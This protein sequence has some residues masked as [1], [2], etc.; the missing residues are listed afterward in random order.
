MVDTT[1]LLVLG[2]GGYFYMKE[3]EKKKKEQ[4]AAGENAV[5]PEVDPETGE[6]I[7]PESSHEEIPYEA[8]PEGSEWCEYCDCPYNG[9][10]DNDTDACTCKGNQEYGMDKNSDACRCEYNPDDPN[11]LAPE[12]IECEC[13]NNPTK[14]KCIDRVGLADE[15]IEGLKITG[16]NAACLIGAKTEQ[17][18]CNSDSVA[19]CKA[20]QAGMVALGVIGAT[21]APIDLMSNGLK[22]ALGKERTYE[23]GA[24][25]LAKT[26]NGKLTTKDLEGL[27]VGGDALK[28][29]IKSEGAST[30]VKTG[31]MIAFAF[32]PPGGFLQQMAV[33]AVSALIDALDPY[34][35]DNIIVKESLDQVYMDVGLELEAAISNAFDSCL[36]RAGCGP[37]NSDEECDRAMQDDCYNYTPI[38]DM[39]DY[40]NATPTYVFHPKPPFPFCDPDTDE[41]CKQ[42]DVYNKALDEYAD[43]HIQEY[44]DA[45][46]DPVYTEE[47]T[48]PETASFFA[49]EAVEGPLKKDNMKFILPALAFLLV[50]K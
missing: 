41:L 30:G 33:A 2:A 4:A 25:V 12:T 24:D 10:Y 36:E 37:D 43:E 7:Y 29:N 19:A 27:G 8:D 5:E 17:C 35:Y 44:L 32:A 26:R 18:P 49:S 48:D 40:V 16:D 21:M 46:M 47:Y 1:T 11:A 42:D 23:G 3:Q 50:A 28:G 14:Q 39:G 13:L 22:K 6:L 34:D 15:T 45:G 31:I 20:E 9:N 38:V